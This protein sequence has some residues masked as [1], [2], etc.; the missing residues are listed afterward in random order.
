M[1]SLGNT[2]EVPGRQERTNW[3]AWEGPG[4]QERTNWTAYEAPGRQERTREA[5][6]D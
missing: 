4:R 1:D 3:T 2:R 6:K 5:G